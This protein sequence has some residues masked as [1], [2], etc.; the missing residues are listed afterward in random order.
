MKA[1]FLE[2]RTF[3]TVNRP[4]PRAGRG[5]ALL[6]VV[7]AGICNT[8][9]ELYRGYYGFRGVPGHEFVARVE[10]APGRPDMVGRRVVV[11]INIGCGRC[12]WCERD[13][14]RHCRERRVIG[15][16][17]WDGCFAEYVKAPVAGLHPVPESVPDEVAVFAE[18]LAAALEIGQQVHLTAN[19]KMAI[20]GDGKLGLLTALALRFFNPGLTLIGR[21]GRKLALAEAQGVRV[22]RVDPKAGLRAL[23]AWTGCFDLVVEATGRPEGLAQ[24]MHLVRPEG[25]IVAKTT[26]HESSAIDLAALV[27]NEYTLVGSRC[28]DMALALFFLQQQ[29]IDVAP[30]IEAAYPFQDFETA[31]EHAGRPGAMKVQ[32]FFD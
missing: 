6:R 19:L 12:E 4:K 27:V 16:K 9:L 29:R 18:P 20:L 17:D 24:A 32:I 7:R 28:G 22:H 14:P 8:D 21:H 10:A 25:V 23:E 1:I 13:D 2:D 5:E 3:S 11:D 15:I 30:L 31:F 26:S